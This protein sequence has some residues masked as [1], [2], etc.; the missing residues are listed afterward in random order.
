MN[1]MKLRKENV[2]KASDDDALATFKD[3]DGNLQIEIP[4]GRTDDDLVDALLD[5]M[6]EEHMKKKGSDQSLVLD[7][8]DSESEDI[9]FVNS[10]LSGSGPSP[11]TTSDALV[12]ATVTRPDDFFDVYSLAFKYLL[13]KCDTLGTEKDKFILEFLRKSGIEI[14]LFI[15]LFIYCLNIY[16]CLY[17]FI[18]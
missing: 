4:S 3:E 8:S 2:A 5:H 14:Y 11:A 16:L 17:S 7:D 13:L 6:F 10:D 1:L 9:S 15:Y 12:A 18:F